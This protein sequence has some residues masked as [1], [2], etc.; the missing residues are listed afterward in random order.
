MKVNPLLKL[1]EF[2]QSIWL[3]F[4]RRHLIESGDLERFI[5]EDGLC[6]V[7]SNP[8]IFEKAIAGSHDYDEAI[9]TLSLEGKKAGEIFQAISVWDIQ[10][11]CDRFRPL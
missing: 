5:R 2:G 10:Q 6:G 3:D 7:T 1:K 4:I 8:T 11:A 9:H